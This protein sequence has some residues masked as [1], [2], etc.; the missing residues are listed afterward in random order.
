MEVKAITVE[1]IGVAITVALAHMTGMLI[2]GRAFGPKWKRS[3]G[4]KTI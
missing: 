3:P 1:G 2:L 4:S